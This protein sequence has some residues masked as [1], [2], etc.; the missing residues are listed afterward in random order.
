M[1]KKINIMFIIDF[2]YGWSGGGTETHLSYLVKYLDRDRFTSAIVAFDT[3]D[4][5][6]VENIKKQNIKI[7]HIP[8]KKYYNVDA[9]RKAYILYDLIKKLEIDIVQTF[10][11]KSDTYGALVAKLSGVK[12]IISSKRDVGDNKTK[13]H[14]F[15]N[16]MLRNLFY[17]YIVAADRVGKVVIEKEKAPFSK[18]KK[19]YNGIE[20]KKFY[21]PSIEDIISQRKEIDLAEDDFVVGMVAVF[22]PEKNHNIFFQAIKIIK[23]E[24]KNLKVV[25]VGDGQL[26]NHYKEFCN[27]NGLSQTV[28]FTGA[29]D[30]VIKYLKT[31]DV[32]CLV[33]GS[34]EG[35]SNSILEKMAMGLPLIVS[36]VGGNAEAVLNGI[37]GIVIPPND[38]DALADAII[39]LYKNP[40]KRIGMGLRSRIRVKEHFRLEKMIKQHEEYYEELIRRNQ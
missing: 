5:P 33:P 8:V 9:L 16:I 23:E 36:N 32:A 21:P 30:N 2:L 39:E 15:L 20:T 1:K 3:G 19:I 25:A 26:F 11:F 28:V 24:I 31:F 10:H 6:L 17:G 38:A 37:N 29:T 7:I 14:F 22:R 40:D 13:W 18:I 4:S 34:N 12:H 27:K 35:F